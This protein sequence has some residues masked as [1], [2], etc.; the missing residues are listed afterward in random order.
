MYKVNHVDYFYLGSLQL[1]PQIQLLEIVSLCQRGKLIHQGRIV[2]LDM[3]F[4]NVLRNA[5]LMV[6]TPYSPSLQ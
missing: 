3:G 2:G 1:G 4:V 6:G 5:I